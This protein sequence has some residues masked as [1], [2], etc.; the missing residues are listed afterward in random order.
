MSLLPIS[1]RWSRWLLIPI[2]ALSAT[3]SAQ[4]HAPNIFFPHVRPLPRVGASVS[5]SRIDADIDIHE[6]AAR[7][8]LTVTLRNPSHSPREGQ[9][10]LPVPQGAMLKSFALEGGGVKADAELLPREEARRIYAEITRRLLDP[11]LLEFAGMGALRSSV[12]PVP[13]NGTVRVRLVYEELLPVDGARVDYTLPR[14]EALDYK[15]P[16]AFT[17]RVRSR[18]GI[19]SIYSPT[20]DLDFQAQDRET[21][22]AARKSDIE[23]GPLR[24][25]VVRRDG[26]P[27]PATILAAPGPSKGENYFLLL[28]AAPQPEEAASRRMKREVMVVLDKS[29]SM[30]GEKIEQTL[31]A[32]RQVLGGLEDG[33]RFNVITY[34]EAVES[35]A[36]APVERNPDSWRD[37][38][39]F[40]SGVRVSGGTNI[41]GALAKALQ[42][43]ATPGMASLV[44]FLTDGIP[45]V[46]VTSEKKIRGGIA[47]LNQNRRRIFS[48][49]VGVDVNTPLLSRLADDS[50]AVPVFIL[51]GE[52][53]ELKVA[54]VFRKLQGPVLRDPV[55]A[56]EG[57]GT[58]SDLMPDRI[59]DVFA[60]DQLLLIGRCHD[61]SELRFK[62]SGTNADGAFTAS[63]EFPMAKA[64]N[65][66]SWIARLWATRKIAVLTQA[67]RDLGAD[68]MHRNAPPDMSDPRVAELVN[69]IVRLSK[70]FGVLTEHTAFLA[71]DGAALHASNAASSAQTITN[72]SNGSVL[73]SGA[74]SASQDSNI[75]WQK[76]ATRVD[77]TNGYLD[78]ELKKRE[79]G[80]VC[81]VADKTFYQSEG[82]WVDASSTTVAA[83]NSAKEVAIGSAEFCALVDRLISQNR[84]NCLSLPGDFEITLDSTRYLIRSG[85]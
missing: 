14:T 46:G 61:V 74:A 70:E 75:A 58:V 50:R 5:V 64:S 62:L 73:R 30:A 22:V 19:P 76:S 55:L 38:Q 13:P 71:R 69:D 1:P 65:A 33:E 81:Q 27:L 7:T 35:F 2:A 67:L 45:T 24:L 43:P 9:V 57:N 28:L 78:Q 85:R 23:T 15:V 32:V 8:T 16:W 52:N 47:D 51:P 41:H 53:I 3:A 18:D 4:T 31:G 77:K 34:N 40:L 10:V 26:R 25:S 60:G 42:Q 29:G 68:D 11:A 20:H 49:G 36:P 83:A 79:I 59:P 6:Q 37:V 48:F 12:F 72:I 56:A 39:R 66:N 44:L 82:R 54:S 17:I 84:Q 63:Y 21:V 80:G